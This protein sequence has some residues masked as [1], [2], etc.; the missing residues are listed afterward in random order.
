[1][2][3]FTV[4]TAW[5][6]ISI[7]ESSTTDNRIEVESPGK[8]PAHI[9]PENILEERFARNGSLVRI[10]NKF[11]DPPNKDVGEG[12]DTAF[13][14]MT[15]LGLKAP[16]AAERENS[17]LV[18]IRH[19]RLASPEEAIMDYLLT[20]ETIN[21][22]EARSVTYVRA[23]YQVKNIFGRM[24]KGGV[25]EQVPGTR[26]ASTAYRKPFSKAP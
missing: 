23:D 11:P 14:A 1:M 7:F 9:T 18:S 5:A 6:T 16:V 15:D 13:R 24:V 8:L 26:T 25:I 20:H 19:E 12:L 2:P 4:T 21:N 22:K 3:F 10:L 17:V